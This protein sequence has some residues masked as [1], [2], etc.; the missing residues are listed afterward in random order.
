VKFANKDG[1][2]LVV[3]DCEPSISGNSIT[4][5]DYKTTIV[6]TGCGIEKHRQKAIFHAFKELRID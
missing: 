5:F 6:D 4:Q 3:L 1:E 2:I